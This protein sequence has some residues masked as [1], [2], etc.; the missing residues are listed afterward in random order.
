MT[1]AVPGTVDS[2]AAW[3]Q[4]DAPRTRCH[5]RCVPPPALLEKAAQLFNDK[6]YFECHDFLEDAWAGEHG[7]ERDFLQALISVSV[8]MYHVAAGNHQGAVNLL[9]RGVERLE[10]FSPIHAG[11]DVV[12]LL[13]K[14]RICLE[15]SRRA[16][17]GADITW[18]PDDV[19]LMRVVAVE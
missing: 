6:L 4:F 9:Q 19:P 7:E 1:T 11:L 8:G 14:A 3:S 15:K 17:E 13:D 5:D 16:L 18:E 10:P 2:N 12:S